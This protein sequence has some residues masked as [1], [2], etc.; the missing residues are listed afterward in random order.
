MSSILALLR[1]VFSEKMPTSEIS[2]SR[3][4][5]RCPSIPF[6]KAVSV[7][8]HSEASVPVSPEPHQHSGVSCWLLYLI[9]EKWSLNIVV[10]SMSSLIMSEFEPFRLWLKAIFTLFL[11]SVCSLFLFF[12]SWGCVPQLLR[13][14]Y[15]LRLVIVTICW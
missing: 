4:F 11:L 15:T 9:R 7:C 6:Q 2:G 1:V 3:S 8:I 12:F 5:V 14:F 13:G 10:I